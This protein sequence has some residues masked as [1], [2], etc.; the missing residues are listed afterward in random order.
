MSDDVMCDGNG[1]CFRLQRLYDEALQA[2]R[3]TSAVLENIRKN[4]ET[5][6]EHHQRRKFD[7]KLPTGGTR[8]LEPCEMAHAHKKRIDALLVKLDG[9]ARST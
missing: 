6:F 1:E 4:D 5:Q 9:Q 7:G 3:D 8:W 2:L